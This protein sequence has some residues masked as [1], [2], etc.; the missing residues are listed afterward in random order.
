MI[1]LL[2]LSRLA[3]VVLVKLEAYEAVCIISYN[4]HQLTPS[5]ENQY[6]GI[7]FAQ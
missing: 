1:P 5:V 7:A 4:L 6:Y 3:T 2:Y